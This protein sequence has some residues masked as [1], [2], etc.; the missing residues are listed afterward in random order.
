MWY[1]SPT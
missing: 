1:W